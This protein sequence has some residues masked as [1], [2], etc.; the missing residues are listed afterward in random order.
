MHVAF[1]TRMAWARGPYT[2]AGVFTGKSLR[3]T[4]RCWKTTLKM[5]SGNFS[6]YAIRHL[7]R[8]TNM[9]RGHVAS[10]S[11]QSSRWQSLPKHPICYN[12]VRVDCQWERTGVSHQPWCWRAVDEG[13]PCRAAFAAN[14][15]LDRWR[16]HWMAYT[17]HCCRRMMNVPI[18]PTS[19]VVDLFWVATV[20]RVVSGEPFITPQA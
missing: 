6:W 1:I 16:S 13:S 20:T 19:N 3:Q 9:A 2:A 15:L 10:V 8:K 5:P 4:K 17:K 7:V 14:D 12:D 18:C 11:T